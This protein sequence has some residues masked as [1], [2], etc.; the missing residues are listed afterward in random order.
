MAEVVARAPMLELSV[1]V[2]KPVDF[3]EVA[4]QR[5]RYVPI[6]GGTVSGE[7]MGTIIPGGADWQ[8]VGPNGV[9][10][11]EARYGVLLDGEAVEVRSTGLR[12]GSPEVLAKLATGAI[13][14]GS[15]Y[16]FRT[17]VRFYTSSE[18]LAYLNNLMAIA[19]GERLPTH[20]RLSVYRVL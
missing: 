13:L 15:D 19:V 20:V 6:V 9:I 5:R 12:S 2:G 1:E 3:G 18:K 10:D 17:M 4:G 11:L 8:A 16:Y 7:Y 14:P